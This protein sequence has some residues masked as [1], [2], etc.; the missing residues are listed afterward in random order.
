MHPSL[1]NDFN[2]K[3]YT[4]DL[5]VKKSYIKFIFCD[6]DVPIESWNMILIKYDIQML[7]KLHEIWKLTKRNGEI[8]F[9][10]IS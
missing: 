8:S 3:T 5:Y 2:R 1:R 4:T 7:K 6:T 9:D 10:L